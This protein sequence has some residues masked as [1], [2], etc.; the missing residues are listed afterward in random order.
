[1]QHTCR[2]SHKQDRAFRPYKKRKETPQRKNS[3]KKNKNKQT[4]NKQTKKQKQTNKQTNKQT[5]VRK[6]KK[7]KEKKIKPNPSFDGMLLVNKGEHIFID[8]RY[9]RQIVSN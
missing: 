2:Q 1:M 4:K 5:K 7:K 8:I 6:K 3:I 9:V